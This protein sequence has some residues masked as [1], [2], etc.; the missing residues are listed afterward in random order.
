MGKCSDWCRKFRVGTDNEPFKEIP[1][2]AGDLD[3][4]PFHKANL[5]A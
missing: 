3:P 4:T 1:G 2:D 5:G